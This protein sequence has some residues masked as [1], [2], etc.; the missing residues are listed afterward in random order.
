MKIIK[1][2]LL[3]FLI[4][5]CNNYTT[6][7]SDI[8]TPS[9][10]WSKTDELPSMKLCD[11]I[12]SDIQRI[13]CFKNKLITLISANLNFNKIRVN[14]K[15]ND[16]LFVSIL[17]KKNGKISLINISDNLKVKMEIPL[18]DTIIRNAITKLP[19]IL[20]ATKTNIGIQVSS[21]FELPLIIKSD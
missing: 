14:K 3:I 18:I 2:F 8:I 7:S 11:E 6:K 10:L 9:I 17:I 13:S 19:L 15:L 1:I 16:T 20:P 5:G 4:F 12:N 21:K